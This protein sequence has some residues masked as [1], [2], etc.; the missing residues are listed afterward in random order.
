MSKSRIIQLVVRAL[1]L[2]VVAVAGYFVWKVLYNVGQYGGVPF[3]STLGI[4]ADLVGVVW[5]FF[6]V[7]GNTLE[8]K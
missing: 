2:T 3:L 7:V 6:R 8:G 4:L 5:V 1:F